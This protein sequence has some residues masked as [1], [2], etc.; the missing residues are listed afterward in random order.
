MLFQAL[1]ADLQARLAPLEAAAAVD[2]QEAKRLKELSKE[3]SRTLLRLMGGDIYV[4]GES[5]ML[6]KWGAARVSFVRGAPLAP[7]GRC[8]PSYLDLY[9]PRP[10]ALIKTSRTALLKNTQRQIAAAEAEV[11]KVAAAAAGAKATVAALQ[12]AMDGIGGA[13]LQKLKVGCS[14]GYFFPRRFVSLVPAASREASH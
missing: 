1:A 8:A 4:A 6:M 11:S 5:A 10:S 7:S 13:P 2:P 3:A 12:A 14:R 9:S